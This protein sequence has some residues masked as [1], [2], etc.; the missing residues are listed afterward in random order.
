M[1]LSKSHQMTNNIKDRL[2]FLFP[3]CGLRTGSLFHHHDFSLARAEH[4]E[5]INAICTL[6]LDICKRDHAAINLKCIFYVSMLQCEYFMLSVCLFFFQAS[7]IEYYD[8]K[9]DSDY[10]SDM[11]CV[12]NI[13]AL[14]QFA[15][16]PGRTDTAVW[17]DTIDGFS[18]TNWEL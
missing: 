12:F 16:L 17:T 7:A 5:K 1:N 9:A 3:T 2:T 15:K 6:V 14:C 8:S 11:F 13:F 10:V 18:V 4:E